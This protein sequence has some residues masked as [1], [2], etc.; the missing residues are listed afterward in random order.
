MRQAANSRT[1]SGN[2]NYKSASGAGA[3]SGRASGAL[4]V[5]R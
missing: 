2:S 5:D 3:M 1:V 4:T